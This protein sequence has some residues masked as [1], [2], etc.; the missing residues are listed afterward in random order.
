MRGT[1]RGE[2]DADAEGLLALCV[3]LRGEQ[4]PGGDD[5]GLCGAEEEAAC[6][7]GGAGFAGCE[8]GE[9]CTPDGDIDGD[10]LCEGEELD[11]ADGRE[12]EG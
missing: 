2:P 12:F 8:G 5:G 7:E 10:V 9:D 3:P 4:D 1:A 6:E 11:E